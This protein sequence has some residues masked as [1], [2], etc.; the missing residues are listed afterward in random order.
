MEKLSIA[1]LC[2]YC[3]TISKKYYEPS[4]NIMVCGLCGLL[5][6]ASICLKKIEEKCETVKSDE[7]L[8]EDELSCKN[9]EKIGPKI[10]TKKEKMQMAKISN[11]IKKEKTIFISTKP[12]EY[13]STFGQTMGMPKQVIKN[14]EDI[15]RKMEKEGIL[16]G[17]NPRNRA[18]VAIYLAANLMGWIMDVEEIAD[19]SKICSNTIKLTCKKM[20]PELE[21]LGL[22]SAKRRQMEE[23]LL[24]QKLQFGY[25]YRKKKI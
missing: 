19:V 18:S 12:S 4:T 3:H 20:L 6:D 24:N 8:K 15:A 11:K 5:S 17:K 9:P 7:S 14:A 25:C 22:S 23:F 10:L 2:S 13:V 1:T 21:G 16:E